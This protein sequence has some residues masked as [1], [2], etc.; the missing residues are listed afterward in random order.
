MVPVLF[1]TVYAEEEFFADMKTVLNLVNIEEMGKV[2][3]KQYEMAGLEPEDYAGYEDNLLGLAIKHADEIIS[4]SINGKSNK[5]QIEKHDK[6]QEALKAT[7]KKVKYF[8]I[9][10]ESEEEWQQLN[11]ELETFFGVEN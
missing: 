11:L 1:K 8:T 5:D 7:G 10:D 4:I 2:G 9:S 6:I 3:A